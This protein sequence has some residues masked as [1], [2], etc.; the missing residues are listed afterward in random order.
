MT[1][2]RMPTDLQ[3]AREKE[4]RAAWYASHREECLARSRANYIAHREERRAK[5]K[6]WSATHR[7]ERN[8]YH[9]AWAKA[10]LEES[11]IRTRMY[12]YGIS[13]SEF[14]ALLN[15]Q[16]GVCAI[17]RRIGWNGRGPHI[18]HNHA[19]G[20]IRGIICSSCNT[21]L[22]YIKD[23]PNIARAMA[24]YLEENK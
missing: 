5:H 19:T 23:N 16:G 18:D 22:G 20:K 1:L 15:K 11:R 17:C 2:R 13:H 7:G 14:C 24:D 9:K 6:I 3:I 10:H 12:K 4:R 8:S 21:G